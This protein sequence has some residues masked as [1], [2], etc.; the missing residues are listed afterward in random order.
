MEVPRMAIGI[1]KIINKHYSK[2]L[3]EECLD[4]IQI[5]NICD[6]Y[7]NKNNPAN[8][9]TLS[10]INLTSPDFEKF[11]IA[12]SKKKESQDKKTRQKQAEILKSPEFVKKYSFFVKIIYACL[13]INVEIFEIDN[14]YLTLKNN[15]QIIKSLE[16]KKKTLIS[17]HMTILKNQY[18]NISEPI[19][20]EYNSYYDNYIMK[21][22]IIDRAMLLIQKL[23]KHQIFEK[24]DTLL[25]LILPYFYNYTEYIE[26]YN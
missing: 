1:I 14:K 19:D 11:K 13:R 5:K 20:T 4:I 22:K 18:K 15:Y 6:L 26:E 17:E 25:S 3:K 12:D 23:I 7:K 9:I 10:E 21:I 2:Y 24:T 16:H 8:S